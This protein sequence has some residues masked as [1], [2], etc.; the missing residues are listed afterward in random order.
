MALPYMHG[1]GRPPL[2]PRL[3][4]PW[5]PWSPTTPRPTGLPLP[6]GVPGQNGMRF[7]PYAKLNPSQILD[8][9]HNPAFRLWATGQ[10]QNAPFQGM[11]NRA[12]WD[13]FNAWQAA[14]PAPRSFPPPGV[15]VNPN[16]WKQHPAGPYPYP[17]GG[18]INRDPGLGGR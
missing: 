13:Y 14:H 2:D 10:R 12:F 16:W 7:N 6:P 9:R 5:G 17:P 4:N 11:R 18:G 8:L 1:L 15:P 3:R